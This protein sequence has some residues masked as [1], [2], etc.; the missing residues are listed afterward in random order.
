MFPP[1]SGSVTVNGYDVASQTAGARKSMSLCPQHNVL[2]DEL[3]VAEHL[4]L[5]AAIKGVPWSSLNGSVENCVRQLNL[6]DKQNV[7]S[8]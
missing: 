1:S 5:F 2:Y 6:V 8:A 7:P 4:K 3:T